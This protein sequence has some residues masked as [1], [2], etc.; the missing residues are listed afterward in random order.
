MIKQIVK[1]HTIPALSGAATYETRID[2]GIEVKKILGYYVV[3]VDNG[4]V[5]PEKCKVSFANSSKTIFEP[6]GLAHLIV[7]SSVAIKDRFFKEEP[8]N[9]DGYLNSKLTIPTATVGAMEVQYILLVET[10]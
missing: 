4:S 5:T 3:V 8:F 2:L 9:V 6:V 1:S 7:S 10:T